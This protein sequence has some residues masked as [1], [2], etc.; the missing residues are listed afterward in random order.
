M[1]SAASV[2]KKFPAAKQRRMDRLL[3]KNS[4]GTISAAE[5]TE[6]RGL[7]KEAEELTVENYKRLYE[8]TKMNGGGPSPNAVPVTVWVSER[9]PVES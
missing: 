2:I 1:K 5:K 7:V 8:F 4:E 9:Q 6:L 3:D